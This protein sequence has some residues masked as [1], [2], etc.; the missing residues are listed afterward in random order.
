[1]ER[2]ERLLTGIRPT[3]PLH[4]GHYVGALENLVQLQETYECFF[5]IADYQVS[6]HAEEIHL[7]PRW[8]HEIATDWLAVGLDPERTHFCVESLIP[9]HAELA[10]W[11]SWW[12]PLGRLQRNPTLKTEMAELRG[13]STPVAFFTYPVLQ[14][15]NI[16]LPKADLVPTG[17]DQNPHIEMA[18]EVARRF[19]RV[20]DQPIFPVPE[21]LLG[22][23]PR[24]IGL[25]GRV[26]MGKSLDNAIYLK[27]GAETVTAKVMGMF[28]DPTRLRASDPGHVDGSP[29]F[30]Y[31]DAFNRDEE[32][33]EELK[34]RYVSGQVGDVE[35]K[36]RLSRAIN[37]FLDPI[38]EKRAY[39][40]ARP[41]VVTDALASGTN[42]AR[43]SA[44]A[45]MEEVLSA[46]GLR[47][48]RK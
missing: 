1:M 22:R 48:F 13:K 21:G 4:L 24:L 28:T 31:H 23:V 43:R 46:L 39:Y 7:L 9:E 17:D 15:A 12:I 27:D 45:T 2:R 11:L 3:G 16:L 41:N 14:V 33:V 42:R 29:V 47:Y 32:E 40:E 38:R 6:D 20:V 18:R 10:A 19:N 26:K 34:Q 8:V 36:Q 35:V 30:I 5:L 37:E 44:Q 25:D